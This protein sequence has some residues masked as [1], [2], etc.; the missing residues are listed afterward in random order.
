MKNKKFVDP[1]ESTL[2]GVITLLKNWDTGCMVCKH[3]DR[4]SELLSQC[5]AFPDRIP[6]IYLFNEKVHSKP[7]SGQGNKIVFE[8]K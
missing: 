4:G 8:R 2:D 5:A 1:E 6:D 3:L 7:H